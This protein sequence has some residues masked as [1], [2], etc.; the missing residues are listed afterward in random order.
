MEHPMPSPPADRA[1]SMLSRREVL[2]AAIAGAGISLSGLSLF[3]WIQGPLQT[4]QTFIGRAPHYHVDFPS[5]IL[6]GLRELGVAPEDIRGKRILLK[7]NLVEP[8]KAHP[9]I[10]THPAIIQG[11]A[12]AFLRYGAASVSVGEGPGHR[13]DTL[14]V[15]EESGLTDVLVEDH[16]AFHDLNLM[17]GTTVPN[18]GRY[19]NLPTLTFP[20]ILQNVDWIVS[21]A[22]MNTHHW[23]GATLSMK[24]LFGCM[25][26][27]YYGWPKNV[28]HHQGIT[29]SI[30]DITA[31]LAPHF[32]I[33]DGVIG[34]EGD[35][36]IMGSPINA[37]VI[38]MGRNLP[39]VDATACRIM[40][41]DPFRIPYLHTAD[42]WL[43]PIRDTVIDQR[44]EP[45]RTV[46]QPFALEPDV[47]AHQGI[48]L[49]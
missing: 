36:P 28:L 14:L 7:P 38:V 48:R 5:L 1:P 18:H 37:G 27:N 25:P 46:Q 22:K 44:G 15:L 6:S 17:E 3:H 41:I 23:A 47:P 32:A 4:A 13:H 20:G 45:W 26:G 16:L 11:A 19:T 49:I 12:E 35:G 30:L 40:G 31:T 2:K 29:E 42:Q 34:M 43:G 9:H 10:N 39:A 21:M 33:I 8:H 24:N